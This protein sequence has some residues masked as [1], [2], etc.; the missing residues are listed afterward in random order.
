MPKLKTHLTPLG[1]LPNL[2]RLGSSRAPRTHA[3]EANLL[4]IKVSQPGLP[5]WWRLVAPMLDWVGT[6]VK[7]LTWSILMLTTR[8]TASTQFGN[9][10]SKFK[11]DF[12]PIRGRL[13]TLTRGPIACKK[14]SRT[15]LLL[16]RRPVQL[17]L[18]TRTEPLSLSKGG[19][20][21]TLLRAI[22]LEEGMWLQSWPVP[23][24]VIQTTSATTLKA[25]YLLLWK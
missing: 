24:T 13:V 9:Q 18:V 2:S 23:L 17:R 25:P 21:A 10:G 19:S 3:N 15:Q 6:F 1:L 16:G 11:F 8:S 22:F 12:L 20:L 4:M 14:Q 7:H 5:A